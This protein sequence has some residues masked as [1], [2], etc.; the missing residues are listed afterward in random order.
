MQELK[1]IYEEKNFRKL[2]ESYYAPLNMFAVSFIDSRDEAEDIVQEV[3]VNLWEK[4]LDFENE[5]AFKT[6]LYRS[7]RN[8]CMNHLRDNKVKEDNIIHLKPEDDFEPSIMNKIIKQEVYRQLSDAV[9]ELP[10]QCRK[11]YQMSRDGMKPADIAVELDL[12]VETVKS[13]KKRAK[14]LLRERLGKLTYLLLVLN[15]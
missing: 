6:Y 1:N 11:I 14:K 7:V 12:A 9:D 10:Q 3:F 5:T 2:F 13:Q 8:R 4:E 15:I